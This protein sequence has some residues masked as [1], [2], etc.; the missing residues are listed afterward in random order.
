M[1]GLADNTVPSSQAGSAS[2]V[3]LAD[4]YGLDFKTIWNKSIS[5]FLVQYAMF[6]FDIDQMVFSPADT[7]L[8][9]ALKNT[10]VIAASDALGSYVRASFPA[11]I[12]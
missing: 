6:Y 4:L 12:M 8:M 3:S 9:L 10:G 11:L 1:S 7:D 5:T 2:S